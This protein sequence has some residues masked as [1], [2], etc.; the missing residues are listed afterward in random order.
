MQ[1]PSEFP[2]PAQPTARKFAS[3]IWF[4][5]KCQLRN[6][7]KRT[8]TSPRRLIPIIL[9]IAYFGFIF[10]T[11]LS[12]ASFIHP[13]SIATQTEYVHALS[14]ALFGGMWLLGLGAITNYGTTNQLA[15]I[16]VLFPTPIPQKTVFNYRLLRTL[17]AALFLPIILRI[18]Y[19]VRAEYAFA[20]A[21]LNYVPIVTYVNI[22]VVAYFLQATMVACLGYAFAIYLRRDTP[23]ADKI[24]S[25][26]QKVIGGLLIIVVSYVAFSI[27]TLGAMP[28]IIKVTDNS[29]LQ[30]ALFPAQFGTWMVQS[31]EKGWIWLLIGIGGYSL[32]AAAAYRTSLGSLDWFY[33]LSAT[34]GSILARRIQAARTGNI[35]NITTE[36]AQKGK[37]KARGRG[38]AQR[39]RVQGNASFLWREIALSFRR[40]PWLTGF[41]LVVG[42]FYASMPFLLPTHSRALQRHEDLAMTF[43]FALG[44]QALGIFYAMTSLIQTGVPYFFQQTEML[45]SLPFS[46]TRIVAMEVISKAWLPVFVVPASCVIDI[47]VAPDSIRVAGAALLFSPCVSFL[48]SAIWYFAYIL[49][50]DYSDVAQRFI[51]SMLAMAIMMLSIVPVVLVLI[52]GFIL[53]GPLLAAFLGAIVALA[54]TVLFTYLGGNGYEKYVMKD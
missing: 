54:E 24:N 39:I 3:V 16:E 6:Q 37:I 28:G 9:L 8:T 18:F 21:T 7:F 20:S 22:A 25:I 19:S 32:I 34:K 26:Y 2:R 46:S 4:L 45:K 36:L 27:Y 31:P 13:P 12:E 38:L 1:A 53:E 11:T 52:I 30:I 23:L 17:A 47:F 42:T 35:R 49:L 29:Y 50:P 40:S 14:F 41:M 48:F 44:M 33:D 51:R 10:A 15:E 43:G 5:W